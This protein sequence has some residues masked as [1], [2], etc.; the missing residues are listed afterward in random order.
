MSLVVL[1]ILPSSRDDFRAKLERF[2][3]LGNITSVQIDVVDKRFAT[4]VSWP[5]TAPEQLHEMVQQAEMLPHLDRISYE[6]DLMCM[7]AEE[8][9]EAWLTLGAT[10]LTF[11]AETFLNIPKSLR[12]MHQRYGDSAVDFGMALNVA[13]DASLIEPY[14]S[15][16]D[17]VQFMGIGSIGKQGQPFDRRV[18]EKVRAFHAKHPHMPLQV[19]GGVSLATASDLVGAGATRLIVGSALT[20]ATNMY[21]EIE[22]FEA[23]QTPFGI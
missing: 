19:D 3:A 9:S 7:D 12:T 20:R 16:I 17:Y 18:I 22:K 15:D 14:L 4:P 6:I 21:D 23:L 1:A 8:A 13:T 11:H 2:S 5:Y 10:R